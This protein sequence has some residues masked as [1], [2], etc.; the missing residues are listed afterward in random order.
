MSEQQ[1]ADALAV[2]S[3][4]DAETRWTVAPV[5]VGMR[6]VQPVDAVLLRLLLD[7]EDTR[8]TAEAAEALVRR[9]DETAFR[10]LAL[11]Y[12]QATPAYEDTA[13]EIAFA[14]LYTEGVD[15]HAVRELLERIAASTDDA[16]E[17]AAAKEM[18]K[19]LYG[20]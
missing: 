18:L 20:D 13:E 2:A 3:S 4:A 8:V 12:T 9:G 7:D 14:V 10:L 19:D 6:G 15:G 17:S 1:L 11:A 16:E 5:L